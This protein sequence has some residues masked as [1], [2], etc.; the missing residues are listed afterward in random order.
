VCVYVYIK[1]KN[2]GEVV[3]SLVILKFC[4]CTRHNQPD[5]H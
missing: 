4:S 1:E 2:V 5:R 3:A